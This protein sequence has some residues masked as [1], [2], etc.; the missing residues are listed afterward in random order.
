MVSATDAARVSPFHHLHSNIIDFQ[1]YTGILGILLDFC[2]NAWESLRSNMIL[3]LKTDCSEP[4]MDG[5]S[6]DSSRHSTIGSGSQTALE[7]P[8]VC[9]PTFNLQN[10]FRRSLYPYK[11]QWTWYQRELFRGVFSLSHSFPLGSACICN[12]TTR[13]PLIFLYGTL[14]ALPL[15]AW[16]LTGDPTKENQVLPLTEPARLSCFARFSIIGID[17]PAL[18]CHKPS[19]VVDGVQLRP[20]TY[21]LWMRFVCS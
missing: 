11:L 3:R 10:H 6:G 1:P 9:F 17:Y 14:R 8:H 19:S 16:V 18:V 12:R 4:N 21:W 15:R 5:Q 7:P 2:S 13:P 20:L